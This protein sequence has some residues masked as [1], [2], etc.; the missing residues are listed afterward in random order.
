ML[1]SEI[2]ARLHDLFEEVFDEDAVI[3]P[4][5]A[6]GDLE[7]WDSI[8]HINLALA[9]ERAFEIKLSPDEISGMHDVAAITSVIAGK[10]V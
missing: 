1:A 9:I 2:E 8:G 7:G 3:T 5:L 10:A 6:I 4:D